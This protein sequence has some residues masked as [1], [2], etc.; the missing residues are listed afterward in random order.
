[1]EV[2]FSNKEKVGHSPSFFPKKAIIQDKEVTEYKTSTIAWADCRNNNQTAPNT[3]IN[4]ETNE[5]DMT[6][7]I[8]P[9]QNGKY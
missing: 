2:S 3:P 4:S 9:L 7:G 1:M 8:T 5:V 6:R